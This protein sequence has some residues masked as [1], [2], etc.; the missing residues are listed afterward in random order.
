[1]PSGRVGKEWPME[2]IGTWVEEGR[3]LRWIAEQVGT[4]DQHIS[5]LCRKHGIE[6]RPRGPRPGEGNG[7]W[8][9]GRRVD[10]DGYI[11][12][13]VADHPHARQSRQRVHSRAGYVLEHRLVMERVL[14]RFLD[15]SEVVHHRNGVNDDNRPE[16]LELFSSN[17]DH[18]RHELTGKCPSWSEEGRGNIRAAHVG[19]KRTEAQRENIRAGLRRG[20][21]SRR[22]SEEGVPPSR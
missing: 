16:N 15:P 11:L 10:R 20:A 14:G 1:M 9:G 22:A 17:S 19:A 13:W 6:T 5:R 3:T 8:T 2:Q 12:L 18:L 4:C 7:A 21:A